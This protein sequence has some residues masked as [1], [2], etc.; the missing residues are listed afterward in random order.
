MTAFIKALSKMYNSETI[1][2]AFRNIAVISGYYLIPVIT[3]V[4]A[5]LCAKIL[6]F[7]CPKFYTLLSGNR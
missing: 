1:P 2:L 6:C 4:F 5:I 7:I 3:I